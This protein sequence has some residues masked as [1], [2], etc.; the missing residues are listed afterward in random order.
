MPFGGA[1]RPKRRQSAITVCVELSICGIRIAIHPA[2]ALRVLSGGCRRLI[3]NADAVLNHRR[4]MIMRAVR[5][6][7]TGNA[8]GSPDSRA[9]APADAGGGAVLNFLRRGNCPIGFQ[10]LPELRRLRAS[11]CRVQHA[12]NAF[13][14]DSTPILSFHITSQFRIKNG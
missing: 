7:V 10:P 11:G 4:M 1:G 3:L 2:V 13:M 12:V 8:D 5:I 14:R 9:D 6:R